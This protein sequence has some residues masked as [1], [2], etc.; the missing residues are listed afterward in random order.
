MNHNH[1]QI[2]NILQ[3]NA[4]SLN[5]LTK[6]TK[7]IQLYSFLNEKL[8]DIALIC[9][10]NFATDD[11]VPTDC[12][13]KIYRLDRDSTTR[14]GGVAIFVRKT[15]AHRLL[16]TP[17]TKKIE[18]IGIEILL[19]NQDR[20]KFY[21]IYLPGG[22]SHQDVAT[23]FRHDLRKLTASKN[24]FVVGDFNAKHRLWNCNRANAA[25]NR[26]MNFGLNIF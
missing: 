10:T 1:P 17:G 24:Y 9:E 21:S 5:V 19:H 26:H 25:G 23:Y 7:I 4:N 16:P 18:A 14:S 12:N 11:I 15:I 20:M 2:L 22:T 6:P 13:F 8:I 3:W